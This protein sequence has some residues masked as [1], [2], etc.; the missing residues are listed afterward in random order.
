[1]IFG[2]LQVWFMEKH[3]FCQAALGKRKTVLMHKQWVS[4]YM[5]RI[6][7]ITEKLIKP[8]APLTPEKAR[9]NALKQSVDRSKEQLNT[10]RERQHDKRE[11]ERKSKQ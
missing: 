9:I 2:G 1:V 7:E 11:A 5:M 10:E 8:V 3:D 4:K 6:K